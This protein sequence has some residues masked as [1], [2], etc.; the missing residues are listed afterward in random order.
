MIGHK[1]E[2][3]CPEL[4][5]FFPCLLCVLDYVLDTRFLVRKMYVEIKIVTN[6]QC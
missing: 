2:S 6:S 4:I 5:I 1:V 3:M